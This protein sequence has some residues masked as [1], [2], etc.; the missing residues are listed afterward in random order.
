MRLGC[1]EQRFRN[2]HLP[3]CCC[4]SPGSCP[5]GVAEYRCR[6]RK[7]EEEAKVPE[8]EDAVESP[9]VDAAEGWEDCGGHSRHGVLS[10]CA[11]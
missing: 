4:P 11:V 9:E 3:C 7:E 5:S 8:A 2:L 1:P 10:C 6:W